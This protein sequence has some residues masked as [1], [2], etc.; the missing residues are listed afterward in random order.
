M[1]IILKKTKKKSRYAILFSAL[2]GCIIALICNFFRTNMGI[3]GIIACG[4]FGLITFF[5]VYHQFLIYI[6]I[7]V[8]QYKNFLKNERSDNHLRLIQNALNSGNK[9]YSKELINSYSKA[10][11]CHVNTFTLFKGIY[12]GKYSSVIDVINN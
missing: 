4:L 12:I 8:Q 11:Y 6:W 3:S 7:D 1:S 5:V 2:I 9:E 10:K